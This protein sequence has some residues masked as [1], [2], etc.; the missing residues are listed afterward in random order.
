MYF[1]IGKGLCQLFIGKFNSDEIAL[2]PSLVY[3][4][5]APPEYAYVKGFAIALSWFDYGIQ[6]T[7]GCQKEDK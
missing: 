2:L 3:V 5:K 1:G 6:L 4:P 7:Y